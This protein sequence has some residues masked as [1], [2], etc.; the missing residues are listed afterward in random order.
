MKP[1]TRPGCERIVRYVFEYA[2]AHARRQVTC[3]TKDNTMKLTDGL[4]HRV[5]GEI[6]AEYPEVAA[7]HM[8]IDN[9]AARMATRPQDFDVVV[10]PNL[11]SDIL[12]DVAAEVAG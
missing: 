12:S 4:F 6:A 8:I 9:G 11:C 3:M 5:F 1:I 7:R 2:R 10:T